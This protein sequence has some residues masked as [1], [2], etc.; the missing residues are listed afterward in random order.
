MNDVEFL[1]HRRLFRRLV[2]NNV[3]HTNCSNT[4]NN[5]SRTVAMS[6]RIEMKGEKDRK[7]VSNFLSYAQM[8]ENQ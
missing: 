7:E 2:G 4:M 5:I 3:K 8:Y 6:Q 1:D